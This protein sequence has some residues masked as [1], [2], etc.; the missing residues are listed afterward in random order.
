MALS[1]TKKEKL[2]ELELERGGVA[3][4]SERSSVTPT[5]TVIISLGGLGAKTLNALKGKFTRQIGKSDHVYFR[6]IDTDGDEFNNLLKVKSDGTLNPSGNLEQ[7]EGISLY[8]SA[9]AN[10]L[11]PGT[12]PPN[13]KNWLN[14]ELLGRK[15]ENNGAQQVRQIGRAMLTNDVSYSNVKTKLT[16]VILDAINKKAM[17]G[18]VDVIVIAGVSG[19]TGSGTVVDATYM[20]HDI[21]RSAGCSDYRIAG[22]IYTPD[23]QFKVPTIAMN[24][25]IQQNLKKNGYAALKEIDYFMNIEETNSVYKLALGAGEVVSSKNIFNS[26][27]LV[28]GYAKGGGMNDLNVTIGR[29]TDQL[30]DM[31]T[32]ITIVQDGAPVQMSSSI[33]SNEHAMLASWLGE[34][35]ARR[36]YHRYAS[37]KYQVLG[38]NSIVI[39]RDEILAY[40]V[41]KIYEAV[42]KE[43]QDFTLVNKD[44]MKTVYQQTNI[45]N[46]DAFTTYAISINSNNP[47]NRTLILDGGYT[48]NMIK[49][50][51]MIAYEDAC[52][53][54]QSER[55]KVNAGYQAVLEDQLFN[56]L[57][58]Q[59]DQIFEQYGPYVALKAIEHKHDELSVGNPQEPFPGI[60]EM[61]VSLSNK[62]LTRANTAAN[63]Y[64]GEGG[65]RIRSAA[66]EATSG[67][68]TNHQTINAYVEICCEQ[69]VTDRIDTVLFKTIS[70][71]LN[72]VAVKMN[73][74]N[75]QLFDVYTSI[76][77]EV[78]KL[79]NQDGQYFTK[80]VMEEKG[81]NRSF[82]VDIIK[83]GKGQ[84][85]KLQQYLDSFIS[86]VSVQELARNFI[87]QMR[88][89]K[90][91]WLALNSD[92]DFDVVSEVRELMDNCLTN[93]NMKN[94][95]IEK[96][97]TVA[98]SPMDFTPDQ[99]DAIWNDDSENSPKTIA[100]RSAANQ[101]YQQLS[102]GAQSMANS[103]GVIPLD[104]FP[105]N[106]FISTLKETPRLTQILNEMINA[107]QGFTP[108]VSNSKDKFIITQ[109]Y[110]SIPMYILLG[111]DEYNQTY[112]DHPS[113]GR[114]MDEN[115]QNW[116][117]FP[118]PYTIDSVA[119][120]IASKG[121]PAQDIEKYPDYKILMDVQ[122]KAKDGIEKYGFVKI[123]DDNTG[124]VK[125]YLQDITSKPAD[126]GDFK[127]KLYKAA[128]K[129]KKLD[130]IEFMKENGFVINPVEVSK[131]QTDVDLSIIS[132]EQASE[133]ERETI[134]KDIPVPVP[135]VYKWL[136]KSIKYMDILDKDTEIFEE[137]QD[138]MDRVNS[139]IIGK[140][141]YL[142]AV[143]TFAFAVRTG[144]VK[145]NEN[146]DK[147][148]NYMNGQEPVSVNFGRAR[149]FDKKYYLYHV[150]VSFYSLDDKRLEAFNTQAGK[151]IDN[152]DE[153]N[154][155]SVT[156]H[157]AE[158]LGDSNLGDVFNM[159]VINEEAE[160]QGVTEH[161]EITDHADEKGNTYK[162]LKRFYE[163]VQTSF[164]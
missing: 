84:T 140:R 159:E 120:D 59:V 5:P 51:P 139:D 101:I 3:F 93:N 52:D 123:V 7:E 37:Y 48:K 63:S 58:T 137:L 1:P 22:Y 107:A 158:V 110:M 117:R 30:M 41:N 74:Y 105:S 143:E 42:L 38:Y 78:Q 45:I 111:M 81:M 116:G 122:K 24:P 55:I 90:E 114:H 53:L 67:L 118:N 102:T 19:G 83:S 135:D 34:H 104:Y 68:F 95:I 50:N 14:S 99:L 130:V 13:I 29:L 35:T 2:R 71:A 44:M 79:L 49:Q 155:S 151:L 21:F 160:D 36:I 109:Q 138:V 8:D 96:F 103:N 157:I 148:W 134:Y 11:M 17:G 154:V 121:R 144:L 164:E 88:V 100:L 65:A 132:F 89:N 70:D 54:A 33:M 86:N 46:P 119:R 32:D 60:V 64:A 16:T 61:L 4:V 40:C 149:S 85:A 56:A 10:I 91:K 6:M 146:N 129:N 62:F 26:C 77:T 82:S 128:T 47:I 66:E 161:Y 124:M 94:D 20:I 136:R 23:A 153:I 27:T 141:R 57:K 112:V 97:V 127:E 39:P 115:N 145:Q 142:N 25:A 108:A 125:L 113:A 76:L 152:G 69:A 15:L 98:Y 156:A 18:N 106:Y 147:I 9:I 133:Q 162:V 43:F 131:G 28:S 126:M 87:K 80:G 72:N 163:L 75:S 31:L 150:F 73:E 92:N 12:I